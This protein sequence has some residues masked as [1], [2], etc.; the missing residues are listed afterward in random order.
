MYKRLNDFKKRF[1]RLK[2]VNPQID[3]IKNLQEKGLD[4]VRD[5]FNELYYIYKDKYSKEKDVLNTK[6]KKNYYK[7][8]LVQVWR[9]KRTTD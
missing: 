6:Y 5:L 3:E 9:R 8:L 1:S 2:I 7:N 4:D